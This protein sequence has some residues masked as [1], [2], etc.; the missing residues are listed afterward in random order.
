MPDL[1]EIPLIEKFPGEETLRD[2][3]TNL[4]CDITGL[5]LPLAFETR[6]VLN[7]LIH[8]R[9]G[10]DELKR[11]M[12]NPQVRCRLHSLGMVSNGLQEKW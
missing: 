8:Q 11:R 4:A 6:Q 7:V 1:R 12:S 5:D 10:G 9:K 2:L 3:T